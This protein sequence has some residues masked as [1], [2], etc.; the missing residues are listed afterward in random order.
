MR[1]RALR[2]LATL[3]SLL[4]VTS[5]TVKA[6][7]ISINEVI[8]VVSGS[9][10]TSRGSDL[11]L[12][13][14]SQSTKTLV[15]ESVTKSS[16]G[17]RVSS[18]EISSTQVPDASGAGA[19]PATDSLLS[20]IAMSDDPQGKIDVISEGD[21]EGSICDCGEIPVLEGAGF[22]KWPLLFLAAIPLFFIHHDHHP[23]CETCDTTPTPTPT[24]VPPPPPGVPEPA[25]LL[26]MGS[27]LVALAAS[28][29]R[30]HARSRQN[31][32]AST[33]EA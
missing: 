3:L 29:R 8:Q 14:Y 23:T 10:S 32:I 33:E 11:R 18:G 21:V 27:G 20:G 28:L 19:T 16:V 6:G 31:D 13:S 26:L 25:S 2:P 22:P 30:R 5:T 9:Q 17:S 1:N 7:P 24:P 4:L 15:D 12:R